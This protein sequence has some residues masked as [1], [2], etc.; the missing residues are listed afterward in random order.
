MNNIFRTYNNNL[1]V[2]TIKTD[3]NLQVPLTLEVV[4]SIVNNYFNNT[5]HIRKQGL[6]KFIKTLINIYYSHITLTDL[7]P[8]LLL[9]FKE[10]HTVLLT[11]SQKRLVNTLIQ[12]HN[13]THPDVILSEI[14]SA[15]SY[16]NRDVYAIKFRQH[17]QGLFLTS[18]KVE[19]FETTTTHTQTTPTTSLKPVYQVN[20]KYLLDL[21]IDNKTLHDN[22]SVMKIPN[23]LDIK[24]I[25]TNEEEQFNYIKNISSANALLTTVKQKLNPNTNN[26]D[27]LLL[28]YKFT[29]ELMADDELLKNRIIPFDKFTKTIYELKNRRDVNNITLD[30]IINKVFFEED[31]KNITQDSDLDELDEELFNMYKI[32]LFRSLTADDLRIVLDIN[33]LIT[34]LVMLNDDSYSNLINNIDKKGLEHINLTDY[35]SLDFELKQKL[36]NQL[37]THDIIKY[38][39]YKLDT[40]TLNLTINNNALKSLIMKYN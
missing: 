6:T 7:R 36:I 11:Y 28:V 26:S 34:E 27:Y 35:A 31:L 4:N 24:S 25:T 38:L 33:S 10:I 18:N 13:N 30:D 14:V 19:G 8:L 20:D 9:G 32:N 23:S 2:E 37:T 1:Y 22:V 12:H 3:I 5:I 39:V 16:N 15:H 29:N 17:M 40:D 21:G